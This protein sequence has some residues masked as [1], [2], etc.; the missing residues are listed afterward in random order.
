MT[1]I[2]DSIALCRLCGS[3]IQTYMFSATIMDCREINYYRCGRCDS[4]QTEAPTWL[5]QAYSLHLGT[6]DCGAVQRTLDNAA[7]GLLVAKLWNLHNAFDY[8][9]GDGMLTRLLRDYGINCFLWDKYARPVY[10]QGFTKPDFERP[11]MLFSFEVLEHFDRPSDQLDLLF[12]RHPTLILAST[13][14]YLDQ[15]PEWSYL[16]LKSGR[17]VFFYSRKAI[18]MIAKEHGYIVYIRGQYILF[19][20][21]GF[22]TGWRIALFK[23]LARRRAILLLRAIFL[24]RRP[25]GANRDLERLRGLS[26]APFVAPAAEQPGSEPAWSA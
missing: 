26:S 15:G 3:D 18:D 20:R 25:F 12:S 6:L 1:E 5:D 13:G 7:L 2:S 9:G 14:I 19:V 4:L 8:G 22:A 23:A 24:S 16:S 11:D 21:A 10:A 17:H